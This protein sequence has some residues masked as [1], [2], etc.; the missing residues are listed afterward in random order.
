[1]IK[2]KIFYLLFL[3]IAI[4]CN[5]DI[6]YHE[7][8]ISEIKK[9][10]EEIRRKRNLPNNVSIITIDSCQYI[11]RQGSSDNE[12]LAHR[13]RCKYCVTRNLK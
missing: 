2:T 11:L 8:K 7:N 3:L 1:M 13:G 5:R 9:T 12:S 4:G 10:T 6:S